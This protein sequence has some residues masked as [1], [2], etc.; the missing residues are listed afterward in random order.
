MVLTGREWFN[1]GWSFRLFKFHFAIIHSNYII[2]TG[3]I[4]I[5]LIALSNQM[6]TESI[7]KV[8]TC[9]IIHKFVWKRCLGRI[10]KVRKQMMMTGGENDNQ[11]LCAKHLYVRFLKANLSVYY[12][13]H[14]HTL[15]QHIPSFDSL[16][17]PSP[18]SIPISSQ[19][20]PVWELQ[21]LERSSCWIY[22]NLWLNF[23]MFHYWFPI[24]SKCCS[25]LFLVSLQDD[26]IGMPRDRTLIIHNSSLFV[27]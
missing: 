20:R 25:C 11:R 14:I 13:R 23:L 15:T 19:Y 9:I 6:Q 12:F 17:I 10:N 27:S 16:S 1:K 3:P 2:G 24:P 18:P 26:R 22:C 8:L 5:I 4:S 21:Q 7:F